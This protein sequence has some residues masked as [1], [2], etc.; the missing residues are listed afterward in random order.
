MT[1]SITVD[2]TDISTGV[3]TQADTLDVDFAAIKH[4]DKWKLGL[5][6]SAATDVSRSLG[7]D[8]GKNPFSQVSLG[9]LVGYTF[10]TVTAEVFATRNVESRN[11]VARGN[12]TRFWGRIIVP[13]WNPP[14]P[15]PVAA[16]Y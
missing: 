16:K 4:I 1:L 6:G 14:A 10:G 7:N 11:Q 3:Q 13:V 5:V 15:A 9:G 8:F 2:P 12:D